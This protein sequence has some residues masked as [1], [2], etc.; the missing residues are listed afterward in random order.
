M[1]IRRMLSLVVA[2]VMVLAFIPAMGVQAEEITPQWTV[3]KYN[4]LTAS[5]QDAGD[6]EGAMKY[7]VAYGS[8]GMDYMVSGETYNS[9]SK[10]AYVNSRI[11]TVTFESPTIEEGDK[12]FLYVTGA[13][14]TTFGNKSASNWQRLVVSDAVSSGYDKS[15]FK[16]DASVS[17]FAN[18]VGEK[19]ANPVKRT[20]KIDITDF[21]TEGTTTV[22]L[23]C[24]VGGILIENLKISVEKPVYEPIPVLER[25]RDE[26]ED[27][28]LIDTLPEEDEVIEGE[29]IPEDEFFDED[30]LPEEIEGEE[31]EDADE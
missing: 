30:E 8:G 21:V 27:E 6:K 28:D 23:G 11:A 16:Y 14:R 2:L 13:N 4:K 31:S 12:V 29:E 5:A 19:N 17:Y 15:K 1:K 18:E 22:Y 25:E 26:D 9:T 3:Y 24:P 20:S 10:D 7:F